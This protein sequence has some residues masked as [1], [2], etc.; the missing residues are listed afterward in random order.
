MP[1]FLNICLLLIRPFCIGRLRIIDT[2]SPTRVAGS[3]A[4]IGG[5]TWRRCDKSTVG[6]SC[7]T[8]LV[9]KVAAACDAE[10]FLDIVTPFR[11]FQIESGSLPRDAR[12]PG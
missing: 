6:E 7:G 11:L 2:P 5:S 9:G 1:V 4:R 10:P 12:C 8:L 3:R